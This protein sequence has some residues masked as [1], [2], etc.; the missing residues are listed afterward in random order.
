MSI[1]SMLISS[2]PLLANALPANPIQMIYNLGRAAF[3]I[4]EI[5]RYAVA[6]M[7]I[8]WALTALMNM[9]SVSSATAGQPNK[10]F[11]SRSQ[12]TMGSAFIQLCLAALLFSTAYDLTPMVL[13]ST[14]VEG[15]SP[16]IQGYNNYAEYSASLFKYDGMPEAPLN[17]SR[18]IVQN[19]ILM[20]M[21]VIGFIS[22][23]RGFKILYDNS[24]GS[25]QK[26]SSQGF[27][28]IFFGTLAFN[29]WWTYSL[30]S[31]TLGFDMLSFFSQ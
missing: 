14:M 30:I 19:F 23:C 2:A 13:T 26:P 31:N 5:A 10:M 17:Q 11:A 28:Y 20:F 29:F 7:A 8:L 18:E 9:Y 27:A 4:L 15:A 25:G 1:N 12:P 21:R 16:S 3:F 6:A 22:A 24:N